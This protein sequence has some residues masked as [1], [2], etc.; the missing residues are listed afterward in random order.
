MDERKSWLKQWKY[1]AQC[2]IK[3]LNEYSPYI[4][5]SNEQYISNSNHSLILSNPKGFYLFG[6]LDE[7]SNVGTSMFR[8]VEFIS[9]E[10][11]ID[12]TSYPARNIIQAVYD[13]QQMWGR[14]L[15]EALI[16][17][18]L[19]ARTNKDSYYMHY[20]LQRE[21]W[22]VIDSYKDWKE[23]YGKPSNNLAFQK[24]IWIQTISGLELSID[25]N[26]CWYLKEKNQRASVSRTNKESF[27]QK[28]ITALTETNSREKL[29][30]G[31]TY[32]GYS[33]LS[34]SIH[35]NSDRSKSFPNV[36]EIELNMFRLWSTILCII[37]RLQQLIGVQ[38]KGFN[39]EINDVLSL[40]T[41]E[42]ELIS[43]LTGDFFQHGDIVILNNSELC[44]IEDISTSKYGYKMYK[45]NYI[46]REERPKPYDEWLPGTM[47]YPIYKFSDQKEALNKAPL[48]KEFLKSISEKDYIAHHAKYFAKKWEQGLKDYHLKGD[49]S[50]LLRAF[51]E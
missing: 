21:L 25:L 1:W 38:P 33:E 16:D 23:F 12:P 35:F 5:I 39:D 34:A 28:L 44:M 11:S 50:A 26:D 18:I 20:L 10:D 43:Q 6:I 42:D 46:L 8:W 9:G 32:R 19:F 51:K 14:K 45:L 4:G 37:N 3:I 27:R 13:E 2:S 31:L 17:L 36:K 22:E 48:A 15:L 24:E 49:K 40:P 7:I 29:V 41:N 30:I 47:M